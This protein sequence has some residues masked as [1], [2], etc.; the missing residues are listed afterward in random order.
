[1]WIPVAT[2]I[3]LVFLGRLFYHR[4][5]AILA[6]RGRVG[7]TTDPLGLFLATVGVCIGLWFAL[8][9]LLGWEVPLP[10]RLAAIGVGYLMADGAVAGVKRG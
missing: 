7:R 4:W 3:F 5:H 1:M 8:G 6:A 9:A 2:G 10:W